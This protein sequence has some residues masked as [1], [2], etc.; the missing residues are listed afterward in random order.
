ML[1]MHKVKIKVK[2]DV[3]ILSTVL[4]LGIIQF[5]SKLNP[6]CFINLV[7]CFALLC[8]NRIPAEYKLN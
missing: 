4:P 3:Y 2:L 5:A 7:Y 1:S 6:A 8:L